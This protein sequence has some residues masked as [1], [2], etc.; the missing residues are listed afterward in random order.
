MIPFSTPLEPSA[1]PLITPSVGMQRAGKAEPVKEAKASITESENEQNSSAVS[2]Q[3]G[4]GN[5][6]QLTVISFCISTL[7]G[8]VCH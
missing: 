6:A 8:S 5:G 3:T 4:D 7:L 2:S 1:E